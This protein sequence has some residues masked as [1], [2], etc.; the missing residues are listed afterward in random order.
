MAGLG[1]HIEFAQI[2]AS[3]YLSQSA[4]EIAHESA[5]EAMNL[6]RDVERLYLSVQAMWE[7]LKAR[8]DLK[9]EDLAAKMREI[10]LR[11]GR[12]D[13][14]DA[15]QTGINICPS[16]GRALEKGSVT[17]LWCGAPAKNGAF[18]HIGK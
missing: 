5:R 13:G 3:N 18:S 8:T 17:C 11:D 12:E 4:S 1:Q 15:T 10:D 14:K 7:L 9:D 2:H 6:R 16:C